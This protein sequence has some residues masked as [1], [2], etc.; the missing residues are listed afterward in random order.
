MRTVCFFPTAFLLW[1]LMASCGVAAA[2]ENDSPPVALLGIEGGIGPAATEFIGQGL[3]EAREKDAQLLII[4]MDTP[5][6]LMEATRDIVK[7]ILNAPIPVA[8]FVYPEGSRAASAGTYILYSSHIAVMAP[9]CTTGAATPIRIGNGPMGFLGNG[10]QVMKAGSDA[11]EDEAPDAAQ[12]KII[13]EAVAYIRELANKRGRNAD[14]AEKAVREGVSIETSAAREKNVI[15]FIAQNPEMLLEKLDGHEVRINEQTRTLMTAGSIVFH[16]EPSWRTQLLSIITN[17]NIAYILLLIGIYGLLLEGYN[18]GA[19]VPGVAGA[20]SLL[21]AFYALQILPVN[22]VGVGLIIL[23]VILMVSEAFVPS[24]G[25]LGLGGVIALVLGGIF[26]VDPDIPGFGVDPAFISAVG[27]TMGLVFLALTVFLV[28]ARQ[29]P[30]VAGREDL[31]G[32]AGRALSDF[33]NGRG[34]VF[35][36]GERWRATSSHPL[37]KDDPIQITGIDGLTLIVAPGDQE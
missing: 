36:H 15:D 18:P 32:A 10:K 6:G 17:P 27:I 31:V 34:T 33:E 28:R 22:L 11:V 2:A 3:D 37:K 12:R 21:L 1:I 30:V 20:I 26:L 14:W 25:A 23:G 16:I 5:G 8:V 13:E 9:V 19:L 35:V 29:R 4:T 7:L 24:F